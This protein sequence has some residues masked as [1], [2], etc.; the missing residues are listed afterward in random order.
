MRIGKPWL[1]TFGL[2]IIILLAMTTYFAIARDGDE[3]KRQALIAFQAQYGVILNESDILSPEPLFY[4]V[5]K[6]DNVT[7]VFFYGGKMWT[8]WW[9]SQ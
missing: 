4:A 1:I 7:Y 8:K 5:V 6:S 3:G 2:I 9:S